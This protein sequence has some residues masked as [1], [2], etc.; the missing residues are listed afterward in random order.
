M[1]N[2]K[3][4]FNA[5]QLKLVYGRSS[6]KK[7]PDGFSWVVDIDN[8]GSTTVSKD[9]FL[10]S[11][12]SLITKFLNENQPISFQHNMKMNGLINTIA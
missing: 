2:E 12:K 10:T 8:D 11:W 6:A 9:V 7:S 5:S 3:I 4:I 1:A